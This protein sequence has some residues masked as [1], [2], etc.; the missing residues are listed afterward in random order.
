MG[1]LSATRFR[2]KYTASGGPYKGKDYE[3]IFECKVKDKK[4]FIL[5]QNANGRKVYGL[6]LVKDQKDKYTI[7]YSNSKS[8][9]TETGRDLVSKFFKDP[10]FWWW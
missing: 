6:K 2:D 1:Q 7:V 10:R 3:S 8:G 9:R 5:G 4:E